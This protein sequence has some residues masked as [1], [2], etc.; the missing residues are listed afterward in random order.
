MDLQG[1]SKTTAKTLFYKSFFKFL[2]WDDKKMK[3]AIIGLGLI[4]GSLARA[5]RH[6]TDHYIIGCEKNADSCKMAI[7]E[8][9]VNEIS[10][11]VPLADIYFLA[12]APKVTMEYISENA[13]SFKKGAIVTDVC[14]V[15]KPVTD[16]CE[17]ICEQNGL[18]FVGGH[19]MAGREVSGFKNSVYDLFVNR[20]Y[21]ITATSKTDDNA[22]S[23]LRELVLKIGI[24]NITVT[25]PENHD[26]MIAYT[27]QLPHV[28]A[29]AYMKSPSSRE[30]SGYSAGSYHD[31]SRVSSV[32]ENLWS[33]LFVA[34]KENLAIELKGLITSLKKYLSAVEDGDK[35]AL[36]ELIKESRL[37]KERDLKLNGG[38]KPHKFG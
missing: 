35:T 31:V 3:I 37:L 17:D 24:S 11:D 21:I 4:G 32:D 12:M 5:F 15:K 20:S 26:R 36:F 16:I 27:S 30:H 14:G 25:T 6:Y 1:F 18:N 23:T 22:I 29:G 2:L 13:K 8:G 34:N 38:E 9:A 7:S 10:Q 19:P 33:E 28:L